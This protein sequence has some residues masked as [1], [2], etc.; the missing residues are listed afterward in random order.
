MLRN[1]IKILFRNSLRNKTFSLINLLGLSTGL[2]CFLLISLYVADEFSF[3]RFHE[4]GGRTYQVTIESNFGDELHMW[5]RVPNHVGYTA[6]REIPEIE[7]AAR[8]FPHGFGALAFVSSDSIKLSERAMVWADPEIFDVLSIPFVKG[9]PQKALSSPN[10]VVLSEDAAARYFGS[11]ERAMG[12]SIK[13]DNNDNLELEVTGVYKTPP[14]NTRFQYSIIAAFST[15]RFGKEKGLSWSNASF[16]TFLLTHK[17]IEQ[18]ALEEKLNAMV[19]RNVPANNRWYK[20]RVISLPDVHLYSSQFESQGALEDH[21]GDIRQIRVLIALGIIIILIAAV[22][23]MNLSTAQSQRRAKEIGISK[24]LGATGTQL[25]R[26]FYFETAVFVLLALLVS[27]QLTLIALP[28]F[29]YLT[30]KALTTAIVRTPLFWGGFVALWMVLSFLAGIY[31][32]LYLSGFSPKRVLKGGSAGVG[33]HPSLR[34]SLVVVQFSASIILIICAVVLYRQLYYINTK[35]LGYKPHQVVA[36]LTAAAQKQQMLSLQTAATL[37]PGIKSAALTQA[38]P[39][40]GSS[41]RNIA[42]N[43]EDNGK[44]LTTV[45]ASSEI[46][47]VLGIHLLA[48]RSLPQNKAQGDSTIQV[49]LNKSAI[50]YLGL[51]PEEA[52]GRQVNVMGFGQK[53]EVVGVTEDFHF[54]S[55]RDEIGAY[56]F[57][58]GDGMEGYSYMLL[59]L[60]ASDIPATMSKL[61][62][63][64][65]DIIPSAF[66]YTFLDDRVDYLYRTEHRLAQVILIFSCL[67]VIIACLGLYA[68]AAYTTEQRTKEIGVRKVLGASVLQLSLM[69]SKEFLMLVG[70]AFVIASPIGYYLMSRWLEDFAYRIDLGVL[71]FIMAG[72]IA[73]VIAWTTVS[74]KAIQAA[75]AN[76][77]DSLR[78]E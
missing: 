64:Y 60:D 10:T 11:T 9:N 48:G 27:L 38:F 69:L 32:A 39:G 40:I 26:Q 28:F 29:N 17:P 76:P 22:N 5:D 4:K 55:F 67:A 62:K 68:L 66:V 59:K 15:V 6:G 23:Y 36:V 2:T 24:T 37:V 21:R 46:V 72:V 41:G 25:A 8:I 63:V 49:V 34:K 30:G 33:G 54:A 42:V 73:L 51:T 75:K 57:H 14:T 77:V 3:D 13:I 35:E 31:P 43:D 18:T 71:V 7:K 78:D 56:C 20:L 53:S 44:A 74:F 16:E 19:E 58:N 52:I 61:E 50:D 47:D 70:V 45:Y 65:R 12:K 1:Y